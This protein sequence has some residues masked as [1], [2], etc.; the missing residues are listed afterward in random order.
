MTL[1]TTFG[2]SGDGF[3][4]IL[5]AR[6]TPATCEKPTLTRSRRLLAD[7]GPFEEPHDRRQP[8]PA[9]AF[10]S[11]QS[12]TYAHR[13]ASVSPTQARRGSCKKDSSRWAA[14]QFGYIE[15]ACVAATSSKDETPAD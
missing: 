13:S 5:T 4:F 14:R 1:V 15:W 8:T 12:S 10:D 2:F 6:S 11:V 7:A 9:R 3:A